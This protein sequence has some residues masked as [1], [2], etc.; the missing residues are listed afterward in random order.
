M[1]LNTL[2]GECLH[3]SEEDHQAGRLLAGWETEEGGHDI[4][5]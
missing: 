5:G 3:L 4:T 2:S 1:A